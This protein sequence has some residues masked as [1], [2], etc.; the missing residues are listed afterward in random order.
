[1]FEKQQVLEILNEAMGKVIDPPANEKL[2]KYGLDS[3]TV[4]KIVAKFRK[5]GKKVKFADFMENPT[6]DNWIAILNRTQDSPEK[7]ASVSE[8]KDTEPFDLT[9]VQYAY[10]IGRED[11]QPLGGV[12]CHA[13]YEFEGSHLNVERMKK[14]WQKLIAKHK[15]LRT[16]FRNQKQFVAEQAAQNSCHVKDFSK[17]SQ[18]SA[19]KASLAVREELSHRKLHIEEGETA[20]LTICL[21]PSERHILCIDFALI[22]ADVKSIQIM[23]YDLVHLYTESETTEKN[24]SFNFRKYLTWIAENRKQEKAEATEYWK[25]Q[26]ETMPFAPEL[27]LSALPS[28]IHGQKYT[29]YTAVLKK[30]ERDRLFSQAGK[31][32]VTVPMVLLTAYAYA[33][34]KWSKNERF[35]INVPLF[36]RAEEYAECKNAVGDFTTLLLTVH[37]FSK[38]ESFSERIEETQNHFVHAMHYAAC[39]GVE[40]QRMLQTLH[41]GQR[42]FAPVV[43]ACNIGLDFINDEFEKELGGIR[44]MISQT[45]QVWIDCQ[46]FE[47]RGKIHI[48]W[49]VCDALFPD[50]IPRKMFDTYANFLHLLSDAE[51]NWNDISEISECGIANRKTIAETLQ[52]FP[53]KRGLLHDGLVKWAMQSPDRQAVYENEN[54]ILTYGE[55]YKVSKKFSDVLKQHGV[56]PREHIAVIVPRGISQIVAIYSILFAEAVYVPVSYHQPKE[57]LQKIFSSMNIRYLIC[58]DEAQTA[59]FQG[60]KFQIAQWRE[61]LKEASVPVTENHQSYADSAYIIM[62]S[63]S[64]GEPKG[65]E[66][67]HESAVNTILDVN[68]RNE[69]QEQDNFISV[70]AIDFDLSVYD[71]LGCS[72]AGSCLHVLQENNAREAD[73]WLDIILNRNI[74][75]WNTVPVL[76]EMLLTAMKNRK[77]FPVLKTVMLSGDW[78]RT[79]LVKQAMQFLPDTRLVVMGGATEASIWSNEYV[80]S[81]QIPETWKYMP[82]GYALTGQMYRVVDSH[83]CD[84]PDYVTGELLIGGFGVAKGYYND[85]VKT[86]EKFLQNQISWYRTGDIGYFDENGLLFFQ[87]RKDF[88]VKVK[89]HRIELGEIE[90]A[91]MQMQGIENAV[92]TMREFNGQKSIVLFYTGAAMEEQAL[93]AQLNQKLPSYMIPKQFV[94]LNEIPVTPNGK[95]NRKALSEIP[96]KE[97]VFH[98]MAHYETETEEKLAEIWCEVLNVKQVLREDDYFEL[99]GNS[100]NATKLTYQIQN[101]FRIKLKISQIFKY[102]SLCDM[103]AEIDRLLVSEVV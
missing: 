14:A 66:I 17:M 71:I 49:D 22:V 43:F 15:A 36:D 47:R 69:I 76:F 59:E 40:V 29:H 21:L 57:R 64:T 97:S 51:T 84:C 10:L 25:K 4:M 38:P 33:I 63:G 80:V 24:S 78:V 1:M 83:L 87:G 28:E 61:F 68:Q 32:G 46:T 101:S 42:D 72:Y 81:H 70:S 19:E 74:K 65:V 30:E 93:V 11:D 44:Y 3:I 103:A 77:L 92:A 8:L 62:T 55:L 91:A 60:Q 7:I 37:D 52:E 5:L 20:G 16:V 82:Y 23:L 18:E 34:H 79:D 39:S 12:D 73:G 96:L 90:T 58:D 2:M 50:G 98:E 94:S 99:G 41:H 54:T 6:I 35:L 13:Y 102:P 89:G 9:D 75:I 45:P 86:R 26:T 85:S 53:E 95:I 100:L 67:S 88:Q 27:P 48:S 31:A 56:K